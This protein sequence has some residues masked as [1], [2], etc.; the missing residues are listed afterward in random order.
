MSTITLGSMGTKRL[1]DIYSNS[2]FDMMNT[3][4]DLRCMQYVFIGI[5]CLLALYLVVVKDNRSLRSEYFDNLTGERY[6]ID[7]DQ[8]EKLRGLFALLNDFDYTRGDEWLY[9]EKIHI[10]GKDYL[11]HPIINTEESLVG[12]IIETKSGRVYSIDE[13]TWIHDMEQVLTDIRQSMTTI[14]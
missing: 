2:G 7:S 4:F 14:K 1:R 8:E 10:D 13:S 12:Y 6:A 3:R 9:E 5:S 11:I